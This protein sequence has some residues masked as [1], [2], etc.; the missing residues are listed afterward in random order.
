MTAARPRATRRATPCRGN[1]R[2]SPYR[3]RRRAPRHR[4][5]R[6]GFRI[7]CSWLC[8]EDA[9]ALPS[10][11]FV[12]LDVTTDNS[13][14][15]GETADAIESLGVSGC[16]KVAFYYDIKGLFRSYRSAHYQSR[17]PFSSGRIFMGHPI[18]V[19]VASRA[20][21]RGLHAN[22]A[23]YVR[24]P[25]SLVTAGRYLRSGARLWIKCSVLRS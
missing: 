3:W 25:S 11:P 2:E 19:L 20:A 1:S 14:V 21:R 5:P 10:L 24:A 23:V 15:Y 4:C 16:H 12:H 7:D 8:C 9:N 17:V 6:Q 13:A 22:L 18:T